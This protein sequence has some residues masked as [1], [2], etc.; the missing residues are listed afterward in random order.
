MLLGCKPNPGLI[1]AIDEILLH[2][3][4][5]EVTSDPDHCLFLFTMR[6]I[7]DSAK[8]QVGSFGCYFSAS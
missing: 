8:R 2:S 1:F 7:S 3:V 5:L 6:L 4:K